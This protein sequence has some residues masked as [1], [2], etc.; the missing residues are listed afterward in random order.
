MHDW[1]D[2]HCARILDRLREAAR[3]RSKLVV[4][5]VVLSHTVQSDSGVLLANFGQANF[6]GHVYSV[7][8]HDIC[9]HSN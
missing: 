5:D 9:S 3:L 1:S 4:I 7:H 8:V 6:T 2:V